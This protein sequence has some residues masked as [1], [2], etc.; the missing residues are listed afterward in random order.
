MKHQAQVEIENYQHD[1]GT[2]NKYLY[3]H[4]GTSGPA[5]IV[6]REKRPGSNWEFVRYVEKPVGR[7]IFGW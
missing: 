2:V 4:W 6:K 7:V 1:D 5:Y 3:I